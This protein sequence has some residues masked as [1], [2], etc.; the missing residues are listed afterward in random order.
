[1]QSKAEYDSDIEAAR[2]IIK[3]NIS[4][5]KE[6]LKERMHRE[7][8]ELAFERA[9]KTK[10]RLELIE[11]YQVKSTVVNPTITNVDVFSVI[12]DAE[13]GYVNYLRLVE[14][15]VVF[16]HTVEIK[17]KLDEAPD[18]FLEYAIPELRERF[19]SHSKEVFV[20]EPIGLTLPDA[21]VLFP[22][23][24]DKRHVVELSL[25]NAKYYRMERLKN[26]QIVDP[27]R[28][29]NRLMQQMKEDLR[30]SEEPRHLECFDNSNI[31]GTNPVAACV[32]FKN[33]KPSKKDYRNFNIKTVS[34]PD[35]YASMEEVVYRRYK[36]LLEESSPLPQLIVIDGGKG[37][38]GSALVALEQLGLR[39]KIAIIGIAKR[40]EEIYF[41]GDPVPLYLDKRSETL[42]VIQQARNEAHRFGITHHRN[43]RSKNSFK[44]EL[45]SVE[46]FGPATVKVLLKHFKTV[47]AVKAA[48]KEEWTAVI[49]LAK[50]EKLQ[51]YLSE[52]Q[53]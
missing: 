1:L 44:S 51:I 19:Q 13:Y 27:D 18:D 50:A 25:R 6:L 22:Q 7:A 12:T 45:E 9:Q 28:H 41:P 42:K 4:K 17:K 3:G 49:G 5:V 2:L 53:E 37:Q 23:R 35:D 16:S 8:S 46:G 36:R 26:M 33:G 21:T 20:S 43:K 47:K 38:L 15:A 40:L 52:N 31:Q 30:L 24:G 39:G 34:G 32:V 48:T 29:V 14:G 10:E 11:R